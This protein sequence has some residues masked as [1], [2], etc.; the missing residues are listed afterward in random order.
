MHGSPGLLPRQRARL[1]AEYIGSNRTRCPVARCRESPGSHI[2]EHV[3]FLSSSKRELSEQE[4]KIEERKESRGRGECTCVILVK[5][6]N[7]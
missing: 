6:D 4:E 5:I 7:L 3:G 2:G 1:G